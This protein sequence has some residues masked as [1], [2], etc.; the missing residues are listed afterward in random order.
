[1]MMNRAQRPTR[2]LLPLV[3]LLA[4]TAFP[5]F[6]SAQVYRTDTVT[7]A[8]GRSMHFQ[9]DS[10]GQMLSVTDANFRTTR[11]EYDTLGRLQREIFP[12]GHSRIYEYNREGHVA[13]RIQSDGQQ[14]QFQYDNAGRLTARLYSD[15]SADHFRYDALGRLREAAN[16][17]SKV[18]FRYDHQGRIL[19]E[20]LN[21][22][23]TRYTYVDS[24]GLQRITYPGGRIIDHFFNA[25]GHLDSIME[26]GAHIAAFTYDQ[27][28]RLLHKTLANAHEAHFLR[29]KNGYI[30]QVLDGPAAFRYKR[31]PAGDVTS[32]TN[33]NNRMAS[34]MFSY[35]RA[36]RLQHL[37]TGDIRDGKLVSLKSIVSLQMDAAGYL[38]QKIADNKVLFSASSLTADAHGG[39]SFP[40]ID[41]QGR[42]TFDGA[43]TFSYDAAGRLNSVHSRLAPSVLR[44]A[45][46][47]YDALGRLIQATEGGNNTFFYYA[48]DQIIEE[49]DGRGLVEAT[50]V[51]GSGTTGLISMTRNDDA[52]F[53]HHN[54]LGS[55][56]AL[57]DAEGNVVE[58]Y[59]Y[60]PTGEV[61]ILGSTGAEKSASQD[62]LNPYLYGEMRYD[63]TT[64]LYLRDGQHFSTVLAQALTRDAAPFFG[65]GG[66]LPKASLSPIRHL[67]ISEYRAN[68]HTLGMGSTEER[69][70]IRWADKATENRA[71]R[72]DDG[73][74]LFTQLR[75]H[76]AQNGGIETLVIISHGWGWPRTSGFKVEGGVYG[77]GWIHGFLGN[78]PLN[79][80]GER[81]KRYKRAVDLS[82]LQKEITQENITF[83]AECEIIL[84]GCRVANTGNFVQRLAQIT[85]CSVVASHGGSDG[86]AAP[87]FSSGPKTRKEKDSG[88]YRGYSKTLPDGRMQE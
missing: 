73:D 16:A 71:F 43:A 78:I 49:R 39:L 67:P 86:T 50:Y 82:D 10:L 40:L 83:C 58:R 13:A 64:G 41:A 57:S 18:T 74:D 31:T 29:N 66:L 27:R 21:G 60:D 61:T 36:G 9:F 22:Q 72:F 20:S 34:R 44:D 23:L 30:T 48:G 52:Y 38:T 8:M 17:H 51:H 32:E 33:L 81:E 1:M 77:S 63:A 26:N 88:L 24:L 19:S 53:Y 62:L 76:S 35:D 59:T 42:V 85:G 28:G 54:G 84:T 3:L 7:D 15:G 12:G 65:T 14:I 11:Y 45:N 68:S 79:E 25:Q 80:K 55:V 2:S 47:R 70:L 37:A 87:L 4:L 46:Y 6:L 5:A 56:A 69:P 75:A